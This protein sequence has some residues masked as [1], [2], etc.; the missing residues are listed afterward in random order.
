MTT[1]AIA[2]HLLQAAAGVMVLALAV[3]GLPASAARHAARPTTWLSVDTKTHTATLTLVA[4]YNNAL[5]GFN[6]DGYGN[7]QMVVSVPAG[8]HVKVT[9]SN[10][11]S[12][13]HSAVI[14]PYAKRTSTSGFPL[15]FHGASTTNAT[16]GNAPGNTQR[17]S[18]TASK[19]GAYAIVCA[20]PGH[21]AAGMWDTLNVTHGGTAHLTLP[22]SATASST[23]TPTGS[24]H[25]MEMT[26]TLAGV[27]TDATTHKPLAHALITVGYL[28]K[29]YQRAA[30][31]DS[32]GRYEIKGL[33]ATKG[34]DT[35]AFSPGYIYHHGS[36]QA[37]QAGQ[38]TTYSYAMARDN[39]N[40]KHPRVLSLYFKKPVNGVAH[41]GMAAAQGNGKFSFEMMA[42][43]PQLGRLVVLAHGA[44]T[45]YDGTLQTSGITAGRYT[46]YYVATQ[47]NCFE[48]KTFPTVRVHLG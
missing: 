25:H 14:T 20:V 32:K 34:I 13:P 33:P 45:H 10:K 46:F 5:G 11:G 18:F 23:A 39:Y 12:F 3:P 43:S 7:G 27:V 9:F 31:T 8:Y 24:T 22:N 2:P 48:D 44:G 30:E 29:G 47:E 40:V 1:K 28:T 35:Y 37:I 21:E 17:F 6:F 42:I 4:G 26:G 16:S 36:N 38:T 41:L 15:A 19:E